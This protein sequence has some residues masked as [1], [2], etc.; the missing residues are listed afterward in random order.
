M[1]TTKLLIIG[2]ISL[3][4]FNPTLFA[5]LNPIPMEGELSPIGVRSTINISSVEV[6]LDQDCLY[7]DFNQSL[8]S[9]TVLIISENNISIEQ[10]YDNP[11]SEI[12]SL[13]TL[14]PG[15]YRVELHANGRV[16]WGWFLY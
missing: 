13:D 11:Q 7:L 16:M 15:E 5:N 1:K 14:S 8:S 4:A 3:F 10:I 2:L 9:V 6:S 12:I